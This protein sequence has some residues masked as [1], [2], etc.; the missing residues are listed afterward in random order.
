MRAYINYITMKSVTLN[1]FNPLFRVHGNEQ[2]RSLEV[3]SV[4]VQEWPAIGGTLT[5][6]VIDEKDIPIYSKQL[7]PAAES[8]AAS[9][10]VNERFVFYDHLAVQVTAEPTDSAYSVVVNFE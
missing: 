4:E 6:T 1:Q 2:H 8:G 7:T 3:R 5:L 9:T 10:K